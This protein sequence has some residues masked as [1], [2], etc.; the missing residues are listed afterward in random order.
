MPVGVT[1]GAGL[2]L[3]SHAHA[4][5]LHGSRMCASCALACTGVARGT[6]CTSFVYTYMHHYRGRA[7]TSLVHMHGCCMGVGLALALCTHSIAQGQGLL[8][9]NKGR[10]IA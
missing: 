8:L 6:A 7:L 9:S 2:S 3:V 5:V 10:A 4:R 1:G